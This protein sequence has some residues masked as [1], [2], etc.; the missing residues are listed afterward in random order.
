MNGL[1]NVAQ[2]FL[3]RNSSTILTVLGAAGVVATAVTVA[4]DTPKALKLL[5]RAKQ[6]K[7]EEL[8]PI[9]KIKVAAPAY[10]PSVAVGAT[11]IACVLSANALNKRQQ[12]ALTSAYALLDSSYKKY[13]EKVVEVCG[14]EQEQQVRHELIKD[15]ATEFCRTVH[16]DPEDDDHQILFL[17]EHGLNYFYSTMSEVIMAENMLNR[18]LWHSGFASLND[19]YELLDLGIAEYGSAV[20]WNTGM[21]RKDSRGRPHVN[22]KH[23]PVTIDDGSEDGLEVI[24]IGFDEPS[25]DYLYY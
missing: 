15:G 4:K 11:T 14:E 1:M 19:L 5:E 10:I 7:G 13:K 9:E 22:F 18:V 3:K 12:A 2:R 20:G 6:E 23:T 16:L 25:E 8:T 17:D 24:C 21:V